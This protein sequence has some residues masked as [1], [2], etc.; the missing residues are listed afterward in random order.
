MPPLAG[1][2]VWLALFVFDFTKYMFI[3]KHFKKF[4]K[5]KQQ[6]FKLFWLITLLPKDKHHMLNLPIFLDFLPVF[7]GHFLKIVYDLN[8]VCTCTSVSYFLILNISLKF[9]IF[10]NV[11]KTLRSLQLYRCARTYLIMPRILDR[12]LKVVHFPLL[13]WVI[14]VL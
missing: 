7:A 6:E 14:K 12:H 1:F 10:L 3:L 2:L 13:L 9:L 4:K 11:M 8:F 5:Q